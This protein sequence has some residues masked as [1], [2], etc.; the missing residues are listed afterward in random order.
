MLRAVARIAILVVLLHLKDAICSG[1]V[2]GFLEFEQQFSV[3]S[4]MS[5]PCTTCSDV[6]SSVSILEMLQTL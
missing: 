6:N 3:E 4:I 2:Y 5:I 1:C